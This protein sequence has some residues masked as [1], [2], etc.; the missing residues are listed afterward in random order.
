MTSLPTKYQAAR[1]ALAAA[2]RVDEVKK[3]RNQAIAM[4]VYAKQARDGE[5][6]ANA[7]EI[8]PPRFQSALGLNRGVAHGSHGNVVL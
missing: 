1:R 5:L 8:S 7:T 2:V 4:Q 3:I 6:I